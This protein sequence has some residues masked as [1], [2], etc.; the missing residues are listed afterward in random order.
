[1][2]FVELIHNHFPNSP[3]DRDRDLWEVNIVIDGRRICA[4]TH[5]STTMYNYHPLTYAD[6]V[7]RSA[8]EHA[9][10]CAKKFGLPLVDTT[11]TSKGNDNGL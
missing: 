7:E 8:R 6:M 5:Y 9:D 4:G 2:M 11:S 10:G 3:S 1:V